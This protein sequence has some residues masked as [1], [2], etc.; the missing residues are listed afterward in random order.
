M[1]FFVQIAVVLVVCL[2]TSFAAAQN[3]VVV[4]PMSSKPASD[5]HG[6]I[7][8]SGLDGPQ[9]WRPSSGNQTR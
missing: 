4:I 5:Q 3:K 2:S 1:R 9:P 8:G 7:G 6:H